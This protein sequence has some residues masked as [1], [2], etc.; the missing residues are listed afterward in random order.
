MSERSPLL[1]PR[2]EP[3]SAEP[4][5]LPAPEGKDSGQADKRELAANASEGS[6]AF[7][8]R[9]R[10]VD[11]EQFYENSHRIVEPGPGGLLIA[12]KI[13]DV[14]VIHDPAG[15]ILGFVKNLDEAR[16]AIADHHAGVLHLAQVERE[17]RELRAERI[18][19][20]LDRAR[21]S[22]WPGN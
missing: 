8:Y 7:F 3:I 11:E 19:A 1:G 5:R 22:G 15:E 14:V 13:G 17:R 18:A 2:G 10:P 9:G 4:E 16:Q 12:E 20:G 6:P 21:R